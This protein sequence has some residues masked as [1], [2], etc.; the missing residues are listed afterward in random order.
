[1]NTAPSG[2]PIGAPEPDPF[3]DHDAAYVFGALAPDERTA[4]ERH[5]QHCDA[6]SA[7]V[8]A[9]AGVPGLLARVPLERL[10]DDDQTPAPDTLLPR[11]V[12][13]VNRERQRARWRSGAAVLLA[14]ACVVAVLIGILVQHHST[15]SDATGP[16]G[17]TGTTPSTF[18][19]PSAGPDAT[20]TSGLPTRGAGPVLAMTTVRNVGVTATVQLEDLAWGT[21]ITMR[22]HEA[23]T[24]PGAV[25]YAGVYYLLAVGTDGSRRSVADWRALPGKTV[26]I[27]G[28]TGLSRAAIGTLLLVTADHEVLLKLAI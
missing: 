26:R 2:P 21:R 1:M 9:M 13:Q 20:A 24:A 18:A 12:A 11:L 10:I 15:R 6:C 25:P 23:A 8:A 22:C 7:S 4:Y 19:S 17:S 16:T 3:A 27:E 28:D 14:A 5:L